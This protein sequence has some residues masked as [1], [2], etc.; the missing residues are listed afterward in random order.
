MADLEL[1][2]GRGPCLTPTKLEATLL[3]LQDLGLVV[4]A[5]SGSLNRYSLT[6]NGRAALAQG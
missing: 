1:Y 6:A 4:S 2:F 5:R 3:A